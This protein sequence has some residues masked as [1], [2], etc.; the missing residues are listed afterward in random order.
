MAFSLCYYAVVK[1]DL[2]EVKHWYKKQKEG[3]EKQ[4][5]FEVKNCIYRLQENPF[6]Y[7]VKYRNV[8]TAFTAIFPY[9]IHFYIDEPGQ[10]IVI[11][12]II[13]QSRNPALSHG[14]HDE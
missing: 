1:T 7:E 13:H 6:N 5:A 2:I 12:A 3:L 11:I 4:F 8:R 14:R 9:A 10:Q